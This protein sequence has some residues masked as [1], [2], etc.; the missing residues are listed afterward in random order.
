MCNSSGESGELRHTK[1]LTS[2]NGLQ[3][4]L[5]GAPQRTAA[6]TTLPSASHGQ[7]AAGDG[8]GARLPQDLRCRLARL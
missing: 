5:Q 7:P 2:Q 6:L 1:L 3:N 8:Q 4:G